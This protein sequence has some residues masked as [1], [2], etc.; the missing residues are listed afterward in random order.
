[1]TTRYCY[2]SQNRLIKEIDP[3]GNE[4]VY[5]YYPDGLLKSKTLPG[6]EENNLHL[7]GWAGRLRHRSRRGDHPL[8]LRCRR[9]A[10]VPH[11]RGGA[12]LYLRLQRQRQPA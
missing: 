4:T 2:D 9:Q 8:L 12:H 3:L 7:R 1:A 6:G 11:G 5:E 10:R